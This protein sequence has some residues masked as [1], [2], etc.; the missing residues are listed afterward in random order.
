MMIRFRHSSSRHCGS[1]SARL[2]TAAMA[3]SAQQDQHPPGQEARVGIRHVAL[4]GFSGMQSLDLVGP[5]EVFAKA[6]RHAPDHGPA[7]FR[8]ETW[9]A[10]ASGG[11]IVTNSGLRIADTLPLSRLPRPIDT[12]VVAGGSVEPL[13]SSDEGRALFAWLKANA[14]SARRIASVCTGAFILAAAGL[15]DGRRAT[16]HW[17][18]CAQLQQF[19]PSAEVV[20][21]AIYVADGNIYTSAGVTAGIDLALALVEQDLGPKVALAVARELVL[22]LRRPGGQSQFSASLAAQAQASDRFRD[23]LSWIGDNPTA[24][25]AVPALAARAAMSERSFGR[26]FKA[27]TGM[28]PSTYVE[29]VRLDR[30]KL[31]LETTSWPL[32]RIAE[33]SGLGT[34]AT[35]LR[36]CRRRLGV[37]PEQY[38]GRFRIASAVPELAR[39]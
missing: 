8:Y 23:L 29:L 34:V 15:L 22:Y 13:A 37:T 33:R 16:T 31:L 24:D 20:A 26:L 14:G 32:A 27:Q 4:I 18:G 1:G 2:I 38:R 17:E 21:D 11:G 36:A 28:T 39:I 35:L 30:A 25:L 3:E 9:I 6:S 7:P 10:S 5:L 12:I 19:C